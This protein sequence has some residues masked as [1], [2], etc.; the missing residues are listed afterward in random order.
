LRMPVPDIA[1][2]AMLVFIVTSAGALAALLVGCVD[3]M[4]YAA[5]LS[6]AAGAMAYTTVEM[7]AESHRVA[8]DM[9]VAG[10]FLAGF[11]FLML[12]EKAL[13]HAHR[14]LTKRELAKGGKKAALVAGAIAIHNIPEGLAVATAFASSGPLG[15]FVT[16]AIALQDFPEGA[17]VSAPLA[18]YGVGRGKAVLL[19]VL[20]GLVEGVAAVLGYMFLSSFSLLVP[21]AL[22]FS[23]GA[24]SYVILVEILPDAVEGRQ[25]RVAAAA[26]AA[27]AAITFAISR[28]LAV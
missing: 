12:M 16:A 15:W 26:F 10:G 27:G 19:G 13:P 8:G 9:V 4:K 20:S 1:L 3:R 5:L 22:A 11:A 21:P 28:L 25:E 7:V 23:G 17:M 6:F 14:H 18:C 24:M 2:G